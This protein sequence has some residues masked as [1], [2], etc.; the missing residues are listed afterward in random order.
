MATLQRGNIIIKAEQGQFVFKPLDFFSGGF[1]T[2]PYNEVVASLISQHFGLDVVPQTFMREALIQLGEENQQ[3]LLK[4]SAQKYIEEPVVPLNKYEGGLDKESATRTLILDIILG[5]TDRTPENTLVNRDG[6]VYAIDNGFSLAFHSPQAYKK[7]EEAGVNQ[8]IWSFSPLT[9]HEQSAIL[10]LPSRL[11]E[12]TDK[13]IFHGLI[14]QVQSTV[15][16]PYF[17]EWYDDDEYNVYVS[18]LLN[19]RIS[20][21]PT[22]IWK[23]F[24]PGAG[25]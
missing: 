25:K 5:N 15:G 7:R 23:Q 9:V 21:L 3:V 16:L 14:P 22:L 10:G 1:E 17:E 2:V 6:R 8:E 4:G 12:A 19:F 20:S 13:D 18:G 24:T 11:L